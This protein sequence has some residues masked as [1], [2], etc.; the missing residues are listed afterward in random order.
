MDEGELLPTNVGKEFVNDGDAEEIPRIFE[1][2]V[3]G[4]HVGFPDGLANGWHEGCQ[5]GCP[6]GWN[7]GCLDG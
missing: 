3:E 7:E 5:D 1:G 4:W 6:E 2:L